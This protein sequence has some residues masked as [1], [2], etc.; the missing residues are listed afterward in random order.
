VVDASAIVEF[1]RAGSDRTS[2]DEVLSRS[3]DLHVPEICDVEML[4]ALRRPV[5]IGELAAHTM[6]LL[7]LDYAS[8]PVR[9]HRHLPLLGRA[10]DL[11]D[12]FSPA[13]AMYVAL[14]ER[15]DASLATA[16]QGLA[17][18]AH[19]HTSLEIIS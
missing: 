14:A 9:R 17:R 4:S 3:F 10:Y 7:L 18:T 6:Q 12:N 19:L 2:F 16:D 5:L 8:M 1:L 11:R 15:L 13:D